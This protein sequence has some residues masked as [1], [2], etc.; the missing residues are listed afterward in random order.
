MKTLKYE[1]IYLSEYDNLADA[2]RQIGHFLEAVYN[3]RRLYS[4]LGYVP[5]TGYK[6]Q[7][8]EKFDRACKGSRDKNQTVVP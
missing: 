6:T 4:S 8:E 2:K 7:Y 3:Q 5:P 1:Q